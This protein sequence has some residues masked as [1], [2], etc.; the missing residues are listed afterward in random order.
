M[1]E[2]ILKYLEEKGLELKDPDLLAYLNKGIEINDSDELKH[3]FLTSF[4]EHHNE[5]WYF[6]FI[7]FNANVHMVSR[8]GFEMGKKRAVTMLLLVADRKSEAYGN[9]IPL[10]KMPDEITDKKIKYECIE[11]FKKWRITAK[12]RKF[13]LDIISEARFPPFNYLKGEDPIEL[14]D[15]FGI[16][17]LDVA[18]QMHYE[19]GMK[20]TGKVILKKK[21]EAG[22]K[23][24]EVREINCFGHR[25]H[26]WGT[27]DWVNI[28]KWNWI[29]AQFD[30]RTINI[31]RIEVFG[32]IVYSGFVSTKE[33]NIP[34]KKVDVET[35][36]GYNDNPKWPQ[37]T[38]FTIQT[39]EET[40]IVV[41]KTY[42][43]LNLQRPSEKGITEIFEQIVEFEMDGK[44]GTGISEYMMS[45]K[46]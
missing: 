14:I 3:D 38:K 23:I 31:A 27:R 30:D 33:K 18:A 42:K 32:K 7:D 28:D 34:V 44:K 15:R 20:V 29:S 36:Y 46:N 17:M 16:E 41:S 6:N 39:E 45:V 43:S 2:R 26:S 37:S 24:E 40:F 13:D 10:E 8:I 25:D 4:P 1:K 19:Q 11:P 22:K 35:T 5:S 12:H 9:V 21:D